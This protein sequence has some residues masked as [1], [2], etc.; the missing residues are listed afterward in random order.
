MKLVTVYLK[1]NIRAFKITIVINNKVINDNKVIKS[2]KPE[3]I[4]ITFVILE[5][6]IPVNS[7]QFQNKKG[8]RQ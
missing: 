5:Q 6:M 4:K 7:K 1:T 3:E 2:I 8:E